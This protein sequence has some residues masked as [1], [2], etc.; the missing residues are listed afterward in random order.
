MQNGTV[1]SCFC[2]SG[3][4]SLT[5]TATIVVNVFD[6][7][8]NPPRIKNLP[9][10]PPV[11]RATT[12]R[13]DRVFCFVAEQSHMSS[14][15]SFNFKYLCNTSHC[16]DFDLRR[17]AGRFL[18][19]RTVNVTKTWVQQPAKTVA[20]G[21]QEWLKLNNTALHWTVLNRVIFNNKKPVKQVAVCKKVKCW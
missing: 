10:Y 8:D 9:N 6:A 12:K 13:D 3:T 4:P 18:Y 11:V 20:L 16:N 2:V 1:A 5:G 19:V 14:N 21:E 17:T 7:N 15:P